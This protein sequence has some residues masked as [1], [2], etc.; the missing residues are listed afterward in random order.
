MPADKPA[1]FDCNDLMQEQG[2]D[3]L[4]T[5]LECRQAPV[6]RYKLLT[7]DDLAA[8]PP[9]Q[10][11]IKGV[12]PSHGTVAVFG[13]SGSGKSFLVLDMLQS[14]A[15]GAEWFGRKVKQCAVTYVALEGE[16]GLAGRV[17]AYRMQHG[18]TSSNIRYMVQPF[19]L[20]ESGDIEELVKAV[21]SAGTGGVVVL[22]TLNRAA[23]GADE[24]D[25]R[26]MGQIIAAAKELQTLVGGLVLLVHHTGKDA[27]KG[28]RGHSSLH[29]ALDAAVEVKRNG[30][31]REWLV[32]KSKD[33]ED[34]Q[35]YPFKLEVVEIGIDEDDDL[36]TS[37]TIRGLDDDE[38]E[39][40]KKSKP[41]TEAQRQGITSYRIA[42]ETVG[43]IDDDGNFAGLPLE[44]W[45]GK[46]YELS[47]A[48]NLEAKKKAFQRVRND[49]VT[50][51]DLTVHN[52]VYRPAG[53]AAGLDESGFSKKL[54]GAGHGTGTGH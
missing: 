38:I 27:S 46:F 30:D 21:Q 3:A 23:P 22:D 24:N 44:S 54:R 41:M 42:A 4:R 18:S 11:R 25:S 12:L 34:G 29:G 20:L 47:T 6:M 43:M 40:S 45:R 17:A 32:A 15:A 8:M 37:C 10:W 36:I 26:N 2:A 5:L 48:D 35:S 50:R 39:D 28:L 1:N 51:G 9:L 7:D 33:G 31:R 19:S 16:A 13:A 49:L 52:D 53:F 14:L